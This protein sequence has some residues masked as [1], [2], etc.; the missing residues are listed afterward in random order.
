LPIASIPAITSLFCYY[1]VV[2][3]RMFALGCE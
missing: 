1:P 2:F 3:M